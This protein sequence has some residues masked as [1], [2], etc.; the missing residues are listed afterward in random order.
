MK[1][2]FLTLTLWV[3][4][5]MFG[6]S[7]ALAGEIDVLVDKL[8]KKGLL[9]RQEAE[10]V[11]ERTRQQAI[12]EREVSPAPPGSVPEWVRKMKVKGDF[13][14]RYQWE[15][16]KSREDRNRGRYRFRLGVNTEVADDFSFGFGL[17]TGG[18][19]PRSTNQTMVNSFET[20]DIRLDY[21]FVRYAASPL[22]ALYGGKFK[23]KPV[24]WQTSDLL[25]DSDIRPEGIAAVVNKGL[26]DNVS[27][28]LNAGVFVL[29]ESSADTSDPMMYVLQPGVKWQA[30]DDVHLKVALAYYGFSGVKGASLAHNSGTN[31]LDGSGNLLYKYNSINP[32]VE[33]GLSEP[34]PG[35]VS[36]AALFAD[37]VY[38]SDPSDDNQ[39]FLLGFKLGDKKV[40]RRGQWQFK[41]AYRRLEKDGWLD[42][43]PDS[44]F[45]GGETNVKGQEWI[46]DY[47]LRKNVVFGLDY[48]YTENINGVRKPENLLQVDLKL[49][50]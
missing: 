7:P 40:K 11:I 20:P 46:F 39:G 16:K 13:R 49:K 26:S 24:L 30:L 23:R 28:F 17:A 5:S 3:V 6:L 42:A 47:A 12:R 14:L 34:L 2:V 32:N 25:W 1:G 35:A 9:S 18:T 50:F 43:F 33:L 37:Y 44:D 4:M 45:Y 41:Y 8:M 21:A 10:V 48:Y 22:L 38:N 27:S 15:R 19:D 29:D 31:S 36:Y